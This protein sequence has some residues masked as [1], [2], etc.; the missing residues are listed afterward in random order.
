MNWIEL[1][2]NKVFLIWKLK[3][4]P[5]KKRC[6]IKYKITM[7]LDIGVVVVVLERTKWKQQKDNMNY[8]WR[9]TLNQWINKF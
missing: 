1:K 3:M 7:R 8:Q 4:T 2:S 6:K 5:E 9:E